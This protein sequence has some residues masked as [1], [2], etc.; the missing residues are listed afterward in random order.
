MGIGETL[1]RAWWRPRVTLPAALLLPLSWVFGAL[2][3]L[4]RAA[5]R[6][7]RLRRTR[8]PVPVVIVGNIAV[9][10]A[11]KTPLVIALVD[12]LRERGFHPGIVSRGYGRRDGAPPLPVRCSLH[13]PRST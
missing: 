4:R 6:A 7:G 10:G 8:L 13:I 12:A 3:A 11:G 9:G 5:Y 2:S 1:Q